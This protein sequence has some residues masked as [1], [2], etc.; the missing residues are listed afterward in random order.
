MTTS[1]KPNFIYAGA[2]K[3]GSSWM[4]E[5][6]REHPGIFVSDAKELFYFDRYFDKGEEWYVNHFTS[7][8]NEKAI[9]ELTHDY[10]LNPACAKR[11]YDFN[12]NTKIIFCLREGVERT[13]SEYLY[14]KT[15]YQHV[16]LKQYE[17][18]FG[19]KEFALMPKMIQWSDYY[20]NLK[21]YFDIFPFEQISV[22]FYDDLKNNSEVFVSKLFS[23]LEVDNSFMPEAL[24]KKINVARSPRSKI[25]ANIAYKV[26]QLLRRTGNPALLGKI[27]RRPLFE[28]ILYKTYKSDRERPSI[29][30][31]DIPELKK[32]YHKDY[33]KLAE[34]I[35]IPLP[36]E[37]DRIQY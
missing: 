33:Q 34:L 31:D 8:T 35:K 6:M 1:I 21:P 10:F 27:K 23:F 20:N 28:K 17:Q 19:F 32:V 26:G 9:G 7:A 11:V 14:D 37:W 4:Y 18:G 16:S 30:V 25:L 12:P 24:H 2:A 13:F 3:A 15:I 36:N 29:P 5:I 22:L